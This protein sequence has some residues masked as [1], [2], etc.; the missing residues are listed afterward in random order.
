MNNK[1]H[2]ACI[3]AHDEEMTIGSV[4]DRA[5]NYVDRV[6]VC[7]DG[8]RALS[9]ARANP[10]EPEGPPKT[11]E[12]PGEPSENQENTVPIEQAKHLVPSGGPGFSGAEQALLGSRGSFR[13]LMGV[14]YG[15]WLCLTG[16]RAA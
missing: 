3:P 6:V 8:S 12:I 16:V 4:V 2:V 13:L 15:L 10:M 11:P 7:D 14:G 9:G 1:P 5:L